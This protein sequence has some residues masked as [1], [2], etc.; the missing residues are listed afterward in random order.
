MERNN[1]ELIMAFIQGKI[2]EEV[3]RQ[4]LQKRRSEDPQ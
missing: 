3:L 1:S 4:E 2:T